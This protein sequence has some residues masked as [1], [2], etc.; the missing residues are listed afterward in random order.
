MED[1]FDEI[2]YSRIFQTAHF[3]QITDLTDFIS[4]QRYRRVIQTT[5]SYDVNP[6]VAES[7]TYQSSHGN[8]GSHGG[9][10]GKVQFENIVTDCWRCPSGHINDP[11]CRDLNCWGAQTPVTSK[12]NL[13]KVI[14]LTSEVK[15][16]YAKLR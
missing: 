14:T 9:H 2:L 11:R 13:T 8:C 3:F 4:E 10:I 15:F 7:E 5:K 6:I 1:G 12:R 16:D